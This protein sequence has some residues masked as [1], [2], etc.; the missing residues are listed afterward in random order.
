MSPLSF[1]PARVTQ[2]RL[3]SALLKSGERRRDED[4]NT[5]DCSRIKRGEHA[6][7]Y[8]VGAMELQELDLTLP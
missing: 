6:T 1:A 2:P 4:A 5:S 8:E 3:G 7:D